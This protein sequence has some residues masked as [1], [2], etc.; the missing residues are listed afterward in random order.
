MKNILLKIEDLMSGDGVR[1]ALMLL[2]LFFAMFFTGHWMACWF[3][4]I[5]YDESEVH[6]ITW[7]HEYR[8]KSHFDAYITSLYWAFATMTTVGYGD[9]KPMTTNE[10]IYAIFCMSLSCGL[11]AYLISNISSLLTRGSVLRENFQQQVNDAK[12]F[13]KTHKIPLEVQGR[14]RSYMLQQWA[15]IEKQNG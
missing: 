9:I 10:R 1:F 5:S 4:Y 7:I 3:Y 14:A 11:F 8:D 2:K 12:R 15:E 13:M 6:Q